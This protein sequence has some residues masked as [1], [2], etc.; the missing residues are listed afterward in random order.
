M[1]Y[2]ALLKILRSLVWLKRVFWWLG[3]RFYAGLARFA[4]FVWRVFA[5]L[6]Y[7]L[8][9]VLKRFGLSRER[10]WLLKRDTLQ[11]VLLCL[12]FISALP[13]TK[14]L[15]KQEN[16]MPGQQ[17][18]AY[19]LFGQGEN[20]DLEELTA[21][22]SDGYSPSPVWRQGS[23]E[24]EAPAIYGELPASQPDLGVV[25]AGGGALLKPTL[26]PG[27]SYTGAA[28]RFSAE[29]I[30]QPGDS[31]GGIA[32]NFNVSVA[33]ILWENNLSLRSV[34]RP[35]DKLIILPTTG[36]TH[37]IK[38]GDTIKKIASLYGAKAEDIVKFNVLKDDGTDL[39]VGEK[40][41]VPGGVKPE[42]RSYST[43]PS[44]YVSLRTIAAPA[45]SSQAP[46]VSGF[47]WPTAA[48]IITQYYSWRH[49]AL[50]IAGPMATPNY[51]AKSGVVE[52]AQC[53]WNHGY[54]CYIIINH[55]GGVKTLYG[56]HSRLLVQPGDYVRAGQTIGL[57][58]NTGNVRGVTGIHLHFEIQINGAR[59]NPLKYVR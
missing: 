32:Y 55:G 49:L 3:G 1:K 44:S 11:V 26:V 14:L 46:S 30:V 48:K 52:V 54:G 56:H 23:V 42:A 19:K 35:G 50:D 16:I 25:V 6:N 4:F 41:M 31:L 21:V 10:F 40:I 47:I 28:R 22:E 15:A 27:A 57:M 17:T 38:K 20:F 51:A 18:V 45:G 39:V 9:Y 2:R 12:I 7:K 59:V 36:V 58:G 29:Y 43:V 53:G 33:T 5:R 8:E 37:K 34:I 13:Q 24:A